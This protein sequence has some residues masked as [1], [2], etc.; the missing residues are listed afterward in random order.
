MAF[1]VRAL[2]AADPNSDVY[3]VYWD[4]KLSAEEKEWTREI[5][6][7]YNYEINSRQMAWWRWKLH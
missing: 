5:K 3:R 7:V 1:W 6:K 2:Y 4:G